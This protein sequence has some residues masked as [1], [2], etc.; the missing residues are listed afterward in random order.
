[1]VFFGGFL[2]L[3][4]I[5]VWIFCIVDAITTPRDQVRL[6]PKLAWVAIVVVLM[7]IGSIAWLVAGRPWNARATTPDRSRAGGV[8]GGPGSYRTPTASA[9]RA[10]RRPLSPDDDDEFLAGLAKRAADERR[11]RENGPDGPTASA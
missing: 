10:P 11:N 8:G 7:D 5:G 2:G 4:A 3:L 9:R 6:L 1:M